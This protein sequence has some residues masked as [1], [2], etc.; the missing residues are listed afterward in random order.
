MNPIDNKY[1]KHYFKLIESRK[2][3]QLTGVYTERH[4]IIPR[5]LGGNNA[6]SNLVSLTP[7]EHYIAHL[8]LT[9]MFF[10]QNRYKMYSAF[11]MMFVKN[12]DQKRHIPSSRMYEKARALVGQ[13]SSITNKGRTP[14][15]K[16]I[17]QSDAVKDAVRQANLGKTPWNKGVPRTQAVKDAVSKARIG[18]PPGN[19][20]RKEEDILCEHCGSY[21]AGKGN[22]TRWHGDNCRKKT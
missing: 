8:L 22:F 9:K 20:G 4:H 16:G 3:R 7:K 18:K 6:K 19:K 15:N 2:N 5:S 1:T 13:V 12:K 14:W 17:P 11:H 10:G 21:V